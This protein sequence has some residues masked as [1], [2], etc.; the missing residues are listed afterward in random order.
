MITTTRLTTAGSQKINTR[1]K[2]RIE[3]TIILNRFVTQMKYREMTNISIANRLPLTAFFHTL[4]LA[5]LQQ[6]C[7]YRDLNMELAY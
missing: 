1:L 4:V 6:M 3:M 2:I 5:R 7:V